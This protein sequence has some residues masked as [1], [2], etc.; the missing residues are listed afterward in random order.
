MPYNTELSYCFFKV[1]Q[2]PSD[3]GSC[4]GD[5]LRYFF[6]VR[7][8]ICEEFSYGGCG[9]NRNNFETMEECTQQCNPNSNNLLQIR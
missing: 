4:D 5:T 2:L 8:G 9:G 6:N 1:C 7:K 3:P